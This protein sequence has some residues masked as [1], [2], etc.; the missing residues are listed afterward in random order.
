MSIRSALFGRCESICT[1][2]RKL[3]PRCTVADVVY[4][5]CPDTVVEYT[6]KW[7]RGWISTAK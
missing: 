7:E 3:L 2:D 4:N 1:V 6:L 5:A